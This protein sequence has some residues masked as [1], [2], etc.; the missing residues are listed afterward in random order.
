MVDRGLV[1]LLA[2]AFVA[3]CSGGGKLP[4]DTGGEVPAP[5]ALPEDCSLLAAP[6][7]GT[8]IYKVY[9]VDEL[10]D[11]MVSARPGDTVLL[12]D[13][14]YDLGAGVGLTIPADITVR[15]LSN[16]ANAV[17]LEGGYAVSELVI[18][19]DR[20]TLAAVTVSHAYGDA[21][22]VHGASDARVYGVRVVDPGGRGLAVL[23]WLGTYSDRTTIG[24]VTIERVGECAVGIEGVQAEGSRVYGSVVE[25]PGCDQPG[26]K[27]AS[28][29]KDTVIDRS[30]MTTG[31][32]YAVQIGDDEYVEDD[33][34]EYVGACDGVGHIGGVVRNVFAVGGGVRVEDACEATVAHVSV[35]TGT[36]SWAFSED[37]TIVNNLA[38]LNDNG[39]ATLA[40]NLTPGDADF[41][42]VSGGDLHLTAESSAIDAGSDVGVTD[43]VDGDSRDAT[44]DVGADE[45]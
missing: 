19:G 2:G 45:R 42:D 1:R 38:R 15:S 8:T 3:G 37:L 7:G 28:G 27:F 20:A 34:R 11:A 9:T 36:M 41:V 14:T 16:S 6:S 22:A 21:V 43:D 4:D 12:A 23:P 40:G 13:G 17:V 32:S 31:G 18:L 35:G 5:P 39:G 26:V 10:L 29:S 30:A 33:R 25:Q 44:P 24:C